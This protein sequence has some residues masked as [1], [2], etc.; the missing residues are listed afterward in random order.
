MRLF[1]R[2]KGPKKV[3]SEYHTR[4]GQRVIRYFSYEGDPARKLYNEDGT[5]AEAFIWPDCPAC[6]GNNGQ[7]WV[8]TS[9]AEVSGY[10]AAGV[11]IKRIRAMFKCGY[12]GVKAMLWR[13]THEPEWSLYSSTRYW[14]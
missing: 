11:N 10:S 12:C 5:E 8:A 6:A 2:S 4:D 3:W 7:L 1:G 9:N 14:G 13:N